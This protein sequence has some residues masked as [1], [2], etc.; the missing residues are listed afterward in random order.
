MLIVGSRLVIVSINQFSKAKSARTGAPMHGFNAGVS[1]N[2][3][4]AMKYKRSLFIF[5][6]D[7]RICDDTGLIEACRTSETVIPCF[8]LDPRQTSQNPYFSAN[9]FGFMVESLHDLAREFNAARGFLFVF[10]GY[11]EEIADGL[12]DEYGFDAIFT[13]KDYTP[14]SRMRDA[15]IQAACTENGVIFRYCSDVLLHE[16]SEI[17]KEDGTPYTVFSHYLRR[18]RTLP[19]R[20]VNTATQSNFSQ[21][22][23][24]LSAA[25]L[26]KAYRINGTRQHMNAE[27]G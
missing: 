4:I 9:A 3:A 23:C 12:I 18:A 15:A 2:E 7:L 27:V 26:L 14:F 17:V 6:R 1:A 19:I 5:R 24:Q 16:P 22:L 20:S 11:A 10:Q 8:I 21:R 13:N 25:S